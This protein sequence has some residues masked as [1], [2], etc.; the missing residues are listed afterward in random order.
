MAYIILPGE[1]GA[2]GVFKMEKNRPSW[3]FTALGLSSLI[4]V[5]HFVFGEVS[6]V[7]RWVVKGYPDPGPMPY[8][9]G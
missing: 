5:T 6:V 7:T 9:W 3:L 2:A 1:D 4:Y 8:P